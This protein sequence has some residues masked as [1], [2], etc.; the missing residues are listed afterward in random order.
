MF[1]FKFVCCIINYGEN[2]C[3]I[4]HYQKNASNNSKRIWTRANYWQGINEQLG[5]EA[6]FMVHRE[7]GK[8]ISLHYCKLDGE[9][10][11]LNAVSS[12]VADAKL[13]IEQ[14]K[15]EKAMFGRQTYLL[16]DE[17]HR[18]NKAQSDSVLQAIEEGSIVFTRQQKIHIPQ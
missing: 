5:L 14:A 8:N 3:Q 6:F 2:K 15:K 4:F 9:I 10:R 17:C 12:G 18:W 16:L 7:K 13:I 1:N 11:K